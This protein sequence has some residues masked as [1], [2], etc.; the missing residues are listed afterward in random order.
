MLGG[1]L[2]EKSSFTNLLVGCVVM[3]TL[4]TLVPHDED[5]RYSIAWIDRSKKRH[6]EV[7]YVH[8]AP[9]KEKIYIRLIKFTFNN[10]GNEQLIVN[11]ERKT[12]Q[13]SELLMRPYYR[14][15][16]LNDLVV[17]WLQIFA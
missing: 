16:I 13:S 1:E 8:N 9:I 7:R 6:F 2:I 3:T 4:A 15:L 14:E 12:S 17:L 10:I 11:A 5:Q